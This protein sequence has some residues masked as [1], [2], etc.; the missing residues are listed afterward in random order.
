MNSSARLA[1]RP[2][3]AAL[4]PDC[5][6]RFCP[7]MSFRTYVPRPTSGRSV[8]GFDALQLVEGSW[9]PPPDPVREAGVRTIRHSSHRHAHRNHTL[10]SAAVACEPD[11]ACSSSSAQPTCCHAPH[12]ALSATGNTMTSHGDSL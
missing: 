1:P 3:P 12:A 9:L 11:G 8:N 6:L 10:R 4:F 5:G 2:K 7:V